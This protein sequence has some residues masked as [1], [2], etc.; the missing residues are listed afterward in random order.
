MAKLIIL[1][2]KENDGTERDVIEVLIFSLKKTFENFDFLNK[3]YGILIFFL[4]Y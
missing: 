3:K 1:L 2:E 4:L